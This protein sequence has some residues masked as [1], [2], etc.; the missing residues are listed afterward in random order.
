MRKEIRAIRCPNC[1][2]SD[3]LE[4]KENHYR[5]NSCNTEYFIDKNEINV[6]VRHSYDSQQP[7]SVLKIVGLITIVFIFVF[8]ILSLAIS[9][10]SSGSKSTSESVIKQEEFSYYSYLTIP[11]D[12]SGQPYILCFGTKT[13]R[14]NYERTEEWGYYFYNIEKEEVE[15]WTA[16]PDYTKFKSTDA[17]RFADGNYYLC[18]NKKQLLRLNRESLI[19]E[20]YS[21]I[22]RESDEEFSTGFASISIA[23]P[24]DGDAFDIISNMGNEYR[25]YPLIDKVY[26]AEQAREASRGMKTLLPQA[27]DSTYYMF[28]KKGFAYYGPGSGH[29]IQ[30]MAV[31]FKYNGGGPQWVR[32]TSEFDFKEGK[33]SLFYH[34]ADRIV[35]YRDVTPER[36]YFDPYVAYYDADDLLISVNADAAEESQVSIQ[37]INKENGDV[38]WSTIIRTAERRSFNYFD[39]SIKVGD[40][41][42]IKDNFRT[43]LLIGKDGELIKEV[44][45]K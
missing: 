13:G 6:N 3:S 12:I 17:R 40:K 24:S 7:S 2:N 27:K 8:G 16:T 28:T 31:T 23:Y 11:I 38:E 18:L 25:Y 22:I 36:V 35:T 1:G 29:P 10:L 34:D 32:K 41:Y 44:K 33:V 9:L 4:T 20:D 5:C 30:L 14:N 39:Q 37:K 26:T 42:L 43:F 45:L 19:F 21:P 15:K